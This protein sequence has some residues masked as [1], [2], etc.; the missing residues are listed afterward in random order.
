MNQKS[1]DVDQKTIDRITSMVDTIVAPAM[2]ALVD[3]FNK[4]IEKDNL[5]VGFDF[6]WFLAKGEKDES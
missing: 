1:N 3:S 2:Q 6:N 4:K 5:R